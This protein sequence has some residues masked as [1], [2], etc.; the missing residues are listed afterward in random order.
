MNIAESIKKKRKEYD[1]E[2]QELAKRVGISKVMMCGIEKGTKI[3]SLALTISL[4]DS[5]HCSIDELI[6]RKVG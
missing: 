3:P 2:Q 1:I 4:A 6:G 5:L